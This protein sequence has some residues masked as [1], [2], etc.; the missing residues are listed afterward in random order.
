MNS[1]HTK[2]AL[3]T[4]YLYFSSFV[5]LVLGLYTSR[6]LLQA[7][8]VEDFG[9]F[10]VIGGIIFLFSFINTAMSGATSRYITVEL[11]RGTLLSQKSV[12]TTVMLVHALI[13]IVTL[14]FSETLGLWYVNA[15][16]DYPIGRST[17]V[18][19]VYQ[20]SILIAILSIV[21]V[22]FSAAVMSHEKMLFYSLWSTLSI[23]LR[24][25][26]IFLLH[27]LDGDRLIFYSVLLAGVSLLTFL[28]YVVY[29]LRKFLE[30][31][32]V[33]LNSYALLKE[34]LA[35]A[36][37]NTFNS[38]GTAIRAQGTS[39]VINRFFG[40]LLNAANSISS[41]VSGYIL[42]F[43]WNVVT[44][45]RPQIVKSY[46][47]NDIM[48]MQAD[49]V[50]CIKYCIA[51]YSFIAIPIILETD[52]VLYLWLRD[53]PAYAAVFC[54]V[55]LIGS[56]FGLLNMIVI[57]GIQATSKVKE[58]SLY[59]CSL[60]GLALFSI[61]LAYGLGA[62]P[63]M[64]FVIL[65]ITEL[66]L[67]CV[68]LYGLNKIIPEIRNSVLLIEISKT[69]CLVVV[70][71]GLVYLANSFM[72]ESLLRLVL[73]TIEYATLFSIL[74]FYFILDKDARQFVYKKIRKMF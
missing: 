63:Y 13:A 11:A 14:L 12:F 37:Y 40:V 1:G 8:G 2:I 52:K 4:V 64:A 74:F 67:L 57:I 48:R 50:L 60:S 9:I 23:S 34:V 73:V 3:N 17:A 71:A 32:L 25:I 62:A 26:V 19:W 16:L 30:C 10:G 70:S 38:L 28:G 55:T 58:N 59:M 29:C 53:V 20:M 43:T 21:Q 51:I 24:F 36:G 72:Q 33:K 61:A 68:S 27:F 35:F 7:L 22:P 54:K 69:L 47:T 42:G 5:Q 15:K 49:L 18:F 44:A 66:T 31:R 56:F 39:L 41:M 6:M 45:F 65:A 46:A